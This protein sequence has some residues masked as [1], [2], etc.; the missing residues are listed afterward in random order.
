MSFGLSGQTQHTLSILSYID[1][2]INFIAFIL[3]YIFQSQ[4]KFPC[5]ALGW[6]TVFNMGINLYTLSVVNVVPASVP[7]CQATLF[8][9]AGLTFGLIGC[10]NVLALILF[11]S[12]R[13]RI[14]MDPKDDKRW[15][16]GCVTSVIVL[17][18][19]MALVMELIPHKA[20]GCTWVV[21]SLYVPL[22]VGLFFLLCQLIL[23]VMSLKFVYEIMRKAKHTSCTK[24]DYR[25]YILSVRLIMVFFF[26]LFEFF[27][28]YLTEIISEPNVATA[29]YI[30]IAG[31]IMD[32][33]ILTFSN[34]ALMEI[35]LPKVIMRFSSGSEDKFNSSEFPSRK[36][37]KS[38]TSDAVTFESGV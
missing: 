7:E 36:S 19:S 20:Q 34:R 10:N 15:L 8:I 22:A 2:I 35:V 23:I 16:I 17:V 27:P 30:K 13:L 3:F 18:L 26:Q 24:T 5:A 12:V 6:T 1:L 29:L 28:V 4:R 14:S 33:L 9:E 31:S 38:S 32:A 25:L 37:K 21:P 11:V